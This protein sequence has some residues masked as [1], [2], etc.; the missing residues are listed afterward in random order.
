MAGFSFSLGWLNIV[1]HPMF[2]SSNYTKFYLSLWKR[3]MWIL[4]FGYYK[5]TKDRSWYWTKYQIKYLKKQNITCVLECELITQIKSPAVI[6]L[7]MSFL[8][9]YYLRK[10]GNIYT[11]KLKLLTR[12]SLNSSDNWNTHL[13]MSMH[14]SIKLNK[15]CENGTGK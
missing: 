14:V 9:I 12:I 5:I 4:D 13:H 11:S 8:P 6:G 15:Q 1:S 3:M 7:D 2:R 10:T